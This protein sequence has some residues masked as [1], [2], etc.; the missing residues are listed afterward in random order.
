MQHQQCDRAGHGGDD[1]QE[2]CEHQPA[3]DLVLG[4]VSLA[5]PREYPQPFSHDLQQAPPAT[6]DEQA[7]GPEH[8]HGEGRHS[9]QAGEQYEE[10]R[11]VYRESHG[12]HE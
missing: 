9:A 3:A 6:G 11:D 1:R 5:G 7:A 10:L 8:H 4:G 12:G 2:C